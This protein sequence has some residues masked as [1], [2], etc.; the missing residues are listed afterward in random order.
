MLIEVLL[1][2][3]DLDYSAVSGALIEIVVHL[4]LS[5]KL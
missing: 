5:T 1:I 3:S 2:L 4:Q